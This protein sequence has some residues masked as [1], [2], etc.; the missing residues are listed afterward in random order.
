MAK[1]NLGQ[2][3]TASVQDLREILG[4]TGQLTPAEKEHAA[5]ALRD[6]SEAVEPLVLE[7]PTNLSE[8][9]TREEGPVFRVL[10]DS[11]PYASVLTDPRGVVLEANEA[12]CDLLRVKRDELTGKPLLLFVSMETGES[13]QAKLSH[14]KELGR[15]EGGELVLQPKDGAPFPAEAT[16]G[17]L[18]APEGEITGIYWFLRDVSEVLRTEEELSRQALIFDHLYDAVVVTDPDGSII[19][20]NRGAEKLFGYS[21]TEALRKTPSFLQ[22]D[23]VPAGLTADIVSGVQTRGQWAGEIDFVTKRGEKGTCESVIVP[24][25][26]EEGERVAAVGVYRDVTERKKAVQA[27]VRSEERYRIVSELSSDF[28]YVLQVDSDGRVSCEWMTDAFVRITGYHQREVGWT[29]G[30]LSLVLRDDQNWVTSRT[31]HLLSGAA[32]VSELRI[33]TREGQTRWLRDFRRPALDSS[34]S[35]IDRIYGAAQDITQQKLA[36]QEVQ[37]L[38]SE[39]EDL[40]R[41]R[42]AELRQSEARLWLIAEEAPAIL[43]TVDT[44]LRFTYSSGTGISRRELGP[45]EVP[46]MTLYEFL[47]TGDPSDPYIDA[48]LRALKGEPVSLESETNGRIYHSRVEPLRNADEELI[49]CV[50]VALD[51]TELKAMETELQHAGKMALLGRM[52]AGIAHE[53][54]NPLASMSAR[55]QRL[56]SRRE[57]AFIDETVELL[58]SQIDRM[59][60]IVRSVSDLSRIPAAEWALCDLRGLLQETAKVLRSDRRS[61]GVAI[62]LE[63]HSDE[64]RVQGSPDQLQQVFLNLGLNALDAMPD[65]GT[66][67]IDVVRTERE[68]CV[69]FSDTGEGM[70]K[71]VLDKI[72]EPFFTTKSSGLSMGLGLWLSREHVLAHSGRVDVESEEGRGTIFKVTLPFQEE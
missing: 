70:P 66:L 42:T 28:A 22:H 32:D 64:P 45:D 5:D 4:R 19:D 58:S 29:I 60:R 37:R 43:W 16:L 25:F 17:T 54:G 61:K 1:K 20:W 71:D 7:G 21:R 63:L 27:L 46:G 62:E 69:I 9:L 30:G 56:R 40:V 13:F 72:F 18:R 35:R 67:A 8:V 53:M 68:L 48:H 23:Q 44:N 36:E 6:L 33:L 3:I 14:A 31:A 57:P 34:R 38:N 15:W 24:I 55:L 11:A 52:A 51:E 26:N 59:T 2:R 10:F 47:G 49:G 39:L 50:G 41:E 12:A 65:G